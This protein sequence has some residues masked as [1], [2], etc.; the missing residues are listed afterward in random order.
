MPDYLDKLV[1]LWKLDSA[2]VSELPVDLVSGYTLSLSGSPNPGVT[3]GP[4]SGTRSRLFL[5]SADG[6]YQMVGTND[7]GFQL[8]VSPAKSYTVAVR[9]FVAFGHSE[10]QTVAGQWVDD[11]NAG[12]R[13][14]WRDSNDFTIVVQKDTG[15]GQKTIG[16]AADSFPLGSW[17]TCYMGFDEPNQTLFNHID[18]T[19]HNTG[20][21]SS[22]ATGGVVE[23][24]IGQRPESS[25]YL[26][27]RIHEVAIWK[28]RFL[29]QDEM[30]T[31]ANAN[32]PFPFSQY[33]SFG[34]PQEDFTNLA[35]LD[36]RAAVPANAQ[37]DAIVTAGPAGVLTGNR[38]QTFT[39][40]LSF[41]VSKPMGVTVIYREVPN[42][43][44]V[45]AET[46][47]Q[48]VDDLLGGEWGMTTFTVESRLSLSVPANTTLEV[49]QIIFANTTS[50]AAQAA[51]GGL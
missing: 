25:E 12:W 47:F 23:L 39:T 5:E 41:G 34:D 2:D 1:A 16:S 43:A 24:K 28:D 29:T 49:H 10:A 31:Y 13:I 9:A 38:R 36:G 18:N 33:D 22:I 37:I 7:T 50:G 6:F 35:A 3:E 19:V 40:S 51:Y 17:H 42:A 46:I 20:T 4:I 21:A 30:D 14:D 8:R 32:V 27:G 48:N 26:D 44:Q 45:P 15:G 11:A